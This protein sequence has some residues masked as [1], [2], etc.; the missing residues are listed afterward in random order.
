MIEE[1]F[2]L[3]DENELDFYNGVLDGVCYVVE[4]K[5]NEWFSNYHY[6]NPDHFDLLET[7]KMSEIVDLLKKYTPMDKLPCIDE[8]W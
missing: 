1:I 5:I 3:P 7:K 8:K 6:C 4:Y 2:D